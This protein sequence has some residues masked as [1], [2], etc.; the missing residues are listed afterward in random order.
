M[1]LAIPFG[2]FAGVCVGLVN[3]LGVAYLRAPSMIFTLGMNAVA[4]GLMVY[5][6]GGFSPQDAVDAVDAPARRRPD[7]SGRR[8]S[9]AHLAGARHPHRL[10]ADADLARPADLCHRQPRARGLPF[11]RRYTPRAGHLLRHFRRPARRSAACF[12][13]AGPTVRTRRW[14]IPT[15]CPPSPQSCSAAPTCSAVAAL[16]SAP[17]PA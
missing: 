13:P 9:G 6:T 15:C 7:R 1:S 14:A 5:H 17:W 10:H 12:W 3:G 4:Q 11:R 8:Q 16:H 2:I